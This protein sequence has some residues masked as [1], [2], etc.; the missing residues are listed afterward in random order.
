M[1][2]KK[3]RSRTWGRKSAL[4]SVSLD[5]PVLAGRDGVERRVRS[6]R[7]GGVHR[8]RTARHLRGQV[9]Q[10]RASLS[11]PDLC[12]DSRFVNLLEY[13]LESLERV[14]STPRFGDDPSLKRTRARVSLWLFQDAIRSAHSRASTPLVSTHS[15]TPNVESSIPVVPAPPLSLATKRRD[16]AP[17]SLSLSLSLSLALDV[18]LR[19]PRFHRCQKP[20]RLKAAWYWSR[21]NI[22][23]LGGRKAL[24]FG[25]VQAG[26]EDAVL[27]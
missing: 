25:R 11:F 17:L 18:S 16:F 13:P 22:A 20:R 4:R 14:S 3:K 27:G 15:Q 26:T 9:A 24:S 6:R 1:S 23:S 12:S 10:C 7:R 2:R 19:G 21:G 5:G 8:H